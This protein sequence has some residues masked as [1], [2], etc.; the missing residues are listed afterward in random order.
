[1][2]YNDKLK[3]LK[4]GRILPTSRWD[5]PD[6]HPMEV[7]SQHNTIYELFLSLQ[8][9][10]SFHSWSVVR[11][12][13]CDLGILSSSN[14]MRTSSL[15]TKS[16]SV[17]GSIVF[18]D[19]G[20]V[21]VLEEVGSLVAWC[22]FPH[23]VHFVEDI[24]QPWAIRIMFLK[25]LYK[26]VSEGTP[27]LV[28]G[29]AYLQAGSDLQGG[30]DLNQGWALTGLKPLFIMLY[31]MD[32]CN[33]WHASYNN[34][35]SPCARTAWWGIRIFGGRRVTRWKRRV[36][37]PPSITGRRVTPMYRMFFKLLLTRAIY[38]GI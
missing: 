7:Q 27:C 24:P 1:M 28:W 32:L 6:Q 34:G 25:W 2:T 19:I 26:Y 20:C 10:K 15:E 13:P 23:M 5:G 21:N 4:C 36:I 37:Q 22:H 16:S 35:R 18:P 38:C 30:A 31:G 11:K 29:L 12:V 33:F 17:S 3:S 9:M 14:T 8:T